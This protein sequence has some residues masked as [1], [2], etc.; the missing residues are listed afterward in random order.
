MRAQLFMSFAA[1]LIKKST[2]PRLRCNG[3][4]SS[5][6]SK[7][8]VKQAPLV[9]CCGSNRYRRPLV[10]RG[11]S[12][13]IICGQYLRLLRVQDHVRRMGLAGVFMRLLMDQCPIENVDIRSG[14]YGLAGVCRSR[15]A[16]EVAERLET[17]RRL[18]LKHNARATIRRAAN[19]SPIGSASR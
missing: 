1:Y 18:A 11:R 4:C 12:I 2:W 6:S 14:H 7:R 17:L 13:A 10:R 3:L 8:C 19:A 15:T 16:R 5:T 9:A